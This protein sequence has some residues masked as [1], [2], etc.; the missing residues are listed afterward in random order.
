[1]RLDGDEVERLEPEIAAELPE[2]GERGEKRV[3]AVEAADDRSRRR[4]SR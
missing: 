4:S 2:G 3:G 1:V